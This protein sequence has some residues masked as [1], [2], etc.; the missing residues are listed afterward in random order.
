MGSGERPVEKK[1]FHKFITLKILACVCVFV[2]AEWNNNKK[3]D[4]GPKDIN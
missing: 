1:T 4:T 3:A 2:E